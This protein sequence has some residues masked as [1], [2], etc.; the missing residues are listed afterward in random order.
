M[1]SWGREDVAR[2]WPED[3]AGEAAAGGPGGPTFVWINWE[4][5][6]GSETV[7][8]RVPAWEKKASKPLAVKICR[9]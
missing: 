7:Q 2:W 6:L 5:Q 8:L 3:W 1:G 4:E 9:G